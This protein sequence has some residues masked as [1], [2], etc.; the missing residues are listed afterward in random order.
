MYLGQVRPA[1]GEFV[2]NSGGCQ[3]GC[4]KTTLYLGQVGPLPGEFVV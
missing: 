3:L 2:V 1:P 4:Y